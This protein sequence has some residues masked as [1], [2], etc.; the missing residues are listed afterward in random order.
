MSIRLP[1]PC[2]LDALEARMQSVVAHGARVFATWGSAVSQ[3][4]TDYAGV[5]WAVLDVGWHGVARV[6]DAGLLG[7]KASNIL[8]LSTLAQRQSCPPVG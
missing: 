5:A 1:L 6:A 2:S 7:L 3:G 4:A 8:P